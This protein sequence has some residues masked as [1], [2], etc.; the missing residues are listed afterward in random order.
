MDKKEI[1]KEYSNDDITIVWKPRKCIHS[2]I[3][4]K[5]LPQV[6]NPASKPWIKMKNA[7]TE[8]LINQVN[9][10]PSG[11]LSYYKK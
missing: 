4:V 8:Q 11:A 7:D 2:G 3:C 10:C 6:Y 9:Q 1:I 5:L